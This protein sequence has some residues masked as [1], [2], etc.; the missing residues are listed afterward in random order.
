MFSSHLLSTTASL[1]KIAI[2]KLILTSIVML[3]IIDFLQLGLTSLFKGH[4][5]RYSVIATGI[6]SLYAYQVLVIYLVLTVNLAFTCNIN[7]SILAVMITY[8]NIL[9]T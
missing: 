9:G 1:E 2:T 4:P 7:L 6:T 8:V 5:N 3:S